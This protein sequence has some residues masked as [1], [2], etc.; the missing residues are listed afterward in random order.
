MKLSFEQIRN[1]LYEALQ[2]PTRSSTT[3]SCW[4]ESVYEDDFVYN[5][6]GK[7][8]RAPYQIDD[9]SKVK[10]GD[11]VE[12]KAE[13]KYVAV[14]STERLFSAF[15]E[16][17]SDGTVIRRGKVFESGDFP[18]KDVS[19]DEAD[20]DRAVSTFA[21]VDNDLEHASTILDGHLGRLEKVWRKGAE[22]FGEVHLPAWLD[23]AI[24]DEKIKVSLAFDRAKNIV[25]NGLV[26]RPRIADAAIMSAFSSSLP[27]PI[28]KGLKPE[29]KKPMKL[30]D[31]IK[32]LFGLDTVDD[33]D[34]E[35][36]LPGEGTPPAPSPA[37]PVADATPAPAVPV[38]EPTAPAAFSQEN[39]ARLQALESEIVKTKS[40]AFADAMILGKKAVPAQRDS[41][42]LMFAQAVKMDAGTGSV[43]SATKGVVEG[44]SVEGLRA[45]FAAAPT[46]SLVGESFTDEAVLLFG[47]NARSTMEGD[48]KNNL[49]ALSAL[50]R[51]ALEANAKN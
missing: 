18:D 2:P 27:S 37:T 31:A 9:D 17:A 11:P 32:H 15:K 47:N 30:K 1:L 21:P 19:F 40:F 16:K 45:Y 29:E 41:I 38:A 36:T 28:S 22:L 6:G 25:G 13:T 34:A 20:L 42:A 33:L 3:P 12:V 7:L 44:K 51:K 10:L 4:I 5:K 8:F 43:F 14:F 50:G 49:L 26:L 24:G 35:V 23:E 48:K 46:H 39:D